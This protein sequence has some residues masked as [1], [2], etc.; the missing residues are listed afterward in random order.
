MAIIQGDAKEALADLDAESFH[1]CVTDPPYELGFMNRQWDDSGIAFDVE[2]WREVKRVLKPGAHL[3]AFGGTRTHHRMMAAIEDAGFEIRD[4]LMWV[5]GCVSPDTDI[6]TSE[7]WKSHDKVSINDTAVCYDKNTGRYQYGSI[8]QK[9]EKYN[10]PKAYRIQGD[11]TDQIVSPKHRVLVERG[12]NLEFERAWRLA[13]QQE[14]SVPVLEDLQAVRKDLSNSQQIASETEQNLRR[15]MRKQNHIGKTQRKAANEEQ[16][17]YH[18]S[19]LQNLWKDFL[20]ETRPS[21]R[22]KLLLKSVLHRMA[23]EQRN[24]QKSYERN[25]FV[26]NKR[27]ERK[28]VGKSFRTNDWKN[29]SE[30]ERWSNLQKWKRKL[31]RSGV[32]EVSERVRRN[33]KEKRLRARTQ[34]QSRKRNRQA[35]QKR[36]GGASHRSRPA[37][38][39]HRKLD[40]L[41]Q[42]QRTQTLRTQRQ[43]ETD[44]ATIEPIENYDDMVWCVKVPTGAFVARRN[45][46]IFVTGNSGFPKSMDVS[47]AIDN[48]KGRVDTNVIKVKKKLKKLVDQSCLTLK[49]LDKCCGFRAANYL[50]LPKEGKKHDP[51]VSILPKEEKWGKMKSVIKNSLQADIGE[52]IC[53]NESELDSEIES[54]FKKAD[55]DVIGQKDVIPGVAFE[56]EGPEK[57]DITKPETP[58]AKKWE[59]WGTALKPGYEPICLA[60]KPLS[61]NTV[62][63]NVLK[64]GTG[65]LNIDA[66]RIGG[67][68]GT[69]YV[70][71]G[72]ESKNDYGDGLNSTTDVKVDGLGRWPNNLMLDD[73]AS[74]LLDSQSGSLHARGNVNQSTSGGGTGKTVSPGPK[75]ESRHHKRKLLQRDGGASRFFYCPKAHKNERNIGADNNE[76]PTVKPVEL[77][78][79]LIRLSTAPE[80]KVLDPFGGSGTAGIAAVLEQKDFV[81]IE[82]NADHA[83]LAQK[84]VDYVRNNMASV[85]KQIFDDPSNNLTEQG[86]EIDHDFW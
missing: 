17:L 16:R 51:W 5:Y 22:K 58:E 34:A 50:T 2:L 80:G 68:G 30:L 43:P 32:G 40:A 76:H 1:S 27:M 28:S 79:Y 44:L 41:S 11:H 10:Q 67:E 55:R 75:H 46:K 9:L 60:R 21:R 20:E 85:R 8:Q 33:G 47:K 35:T 15:K 37:K 7:G 38:Q 65:A 14:I 61:E 13:R 39:R 23:E 66:C 69:Q 3:L 6:L 84:R 82:K 4:T 81:L 36:R 54:F 12:G 70:S 83:K 64:H 63:E 18:R 52:I 42:Q 86:A 56:T 26:R 73:R 24:Y 19:N 77:I 45:G 53:W 29:K 48:C 49:E 78:A 57:I 72:E 74:V 62:A 25:S 31:R 59:G 71:G